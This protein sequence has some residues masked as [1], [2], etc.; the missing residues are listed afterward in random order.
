VRPEEAGAEGCPEVQPARSS[1]AAM[2]AA[3]PAR[4]QR[5]R[6]RGEE[7]FADIGVL[8]ADSGLPTWKSVTRLS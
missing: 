5:V 7:P 8:R 3:H 4:A 2:T 6:A 1:D